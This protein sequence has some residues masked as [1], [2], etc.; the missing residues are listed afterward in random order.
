MNNSSKVDSTQID[1]E[2]PEQEPEVREDEKTL[3]RLEL[4]S[5]DRH[6]EQSFINNKTNEPGAEDL[7]MESGKRG[8]ITYNSPPKIEK[9]KTFNKKTGKWDNDYK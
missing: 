7:S 5:I 2:V 6:N 3:S 9:K 8:L 4:I 1:Y